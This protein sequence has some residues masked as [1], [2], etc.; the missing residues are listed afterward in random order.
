M[1]T[2]YQISS[3]IIITDSGEL[4]YERNVLGNT[5]GKMSGGLRFRK[6]I[7]LPPRASKASSNG[8]TGK[9]GLAPESN[10]QD[11]RGFYSETDVHSEAN[12]RISISTTVTSNAN[13]NP[14][15]SSPHAQAS[16]NSTSLTHSDSNRTESPAFTG[17]RT[18]RSLDEATSVLDGR[19]A[20]FFGST[21]SSSTHIPSSPRATPISQ[22]TPISVSPF[23]KKSHLIRPL[24]PLL[25]RTTS[26][27]RG[28]KDRVHAQQHK[29]PSFTHTRKSTTSQ[30][31]VEN[32]EDDCYVIVTPLS[33]SP[34]PVSPAISPSY[35][36]ET[37]LLEQ[38]SERSKCRTEPDQ[39]EQA[40]NGSGRR[41]S[42]ADAGGV[43][44]QD[45]MA[46]RDALRQEEALQ[47]AAASQPNV[48]GDHERLNL[49]EIALHHYKKKLEQSKLLSCGEY[50]DSD[51]FLEFDSSTPLA[52]SKAHA[53]G[54]SAQTHWRTDST[55][56]SEAEVVSDEDLEGSVFLGMP[57]HLAG[58]THHHQSA[59][60]ASLGRGVANQVGVSP[61]RGGVKKPVVT[62]R[63]SVT[64]STSNSLERFNSGSTSACSSSSQFRS[65][66]TL[67]SRVSSH[68]T[69]HKSAQ[70]GN[71][72]P[73]SIPVPANR[74][75]VPVPR[76][77]MKP[78][79]SA[80]MV[81]MGISHLSSSEGD[82]LDAVFKDSLSP[83][84]AGQWAGQMHHKFHSST[85]LN[86]QSAF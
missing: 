42:L 13:M 67:D 66:S 45:W 4:Q 65:S 58:H 75:P 60:S 3:R 6:T 69:E 11:K 53:R 24:P 48:A 83:G 79:M 76:T 25:N 17:V 20:D 14:A 72:L 30:S 26:E 32:Y 19:N 70:C 8:G 10:S 12:G 5:P 71:Y 41:L 62:P 78:S 52:H 1:E 59:E 64:N 47:V 15:S 54:Q 81:T 46:S 56:S 7:P 43:I 63:R 74:K 55:S 37:Q 23:P 44:R 28:Q 50:L 85:E 33:K 84:D 22:A 16:A 82:I 34:T 9:T 77:G 36:H 27:S 61:R 2:P 18:E 68:N 80:S 29:R 21:T 57:S 31:S 49:E 51:V 38:I 40:E 35:V 39:N 73:N 86:S